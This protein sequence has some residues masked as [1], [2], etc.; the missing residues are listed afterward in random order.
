MENWRPVPG[1]EGAYEVS[2]TGRVRSLDRY[3]EQQGRWGR[4]RRTQTGKLLSVRIDRD[5]YERL[6]AKGLKETQVH[7]VVAAAFCPNPEGKPQVNHINGVKTDNRPCNLEW[8]TNSENHLHAVHVLGRRPNIPKG[9]PTL[10][11][12]DRKIAGFRSASDAARFLG[13]G[14]TAVL[15]ALSKNANCQ[16]WRVSYV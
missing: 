1:Y 13:V 4:I 6:S 15:N 12:R 11:Q 5:G 7:R 14:A 8:V 3:V 16:G 10:L 2:D 9:R